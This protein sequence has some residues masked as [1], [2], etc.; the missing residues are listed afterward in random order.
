MLLIHGDADEVVPAGAL[1]AAE[2]ALKSCG[3]AVSAI[4]RPG[5]GHGIDPEGIAL[6]AAFLKEKLG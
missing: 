1:P 4:V 3:I 5:L 6:G 2:R